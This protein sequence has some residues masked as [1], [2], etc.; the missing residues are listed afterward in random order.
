MSTP[1]TPLMNSPGETALSSKR[2]T[3][4]GF[5][6]V[7]TVLNYLDRQVL[8]I[9]IN[10]PG[11]KQDFPLTDS[12]FGYITA[13]FMGAYAIANG[14]SGPFIDKV[15]TKI[16]YAACM[17]WWSLAGI[18]HIFARGPISLGACRIMLGLGEAGN[19]PAAAKMVGEWFPPKERALASGIFNSGASIGAILSPILIVSMVGVWGWKSAFVVMGALGLIW[20]ALWWLVYRNPP[21]TETRQEAA[22]VPALKLIQTR[23]VAVFTLSKI[24]M[25]PVWYFIVVWFAKFLKDAHHVNFT[26]K[27]MGIQAM[28]PFIAAAIGNI[29]AGWLTGVLIGRGMD[30]TRARKLGVTL[31]AL[32][33]LSLI[34]AV[35]THSLPLAI[36]FVSLAAFGYTGYLANTLAFPAEVFPKSAVASVWGLASVG[37]GLGGLVFFFFAGQIVQTIGYQPVFI[38]CACMAMTALGLVLFGLGPLRRDSRFDAPNAS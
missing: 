32:L 21:Q 36:F 13:C 14:L 9:V 3:M 37:S 5:A 24:F 29:V 30:S 12:Q 4:V 34:P 19:W 33:M 22:R 6:F 23:F 25:D 2:W 20:T 35:L 7:A 26:W 1:S 11:F 10:D 38:A 27:E 18:V 31:F 15:G 16:G 17:V 8:S 28:I